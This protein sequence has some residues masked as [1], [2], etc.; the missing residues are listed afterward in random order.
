MEHLAQ[1]IIGSYDARV[2][3]VAAI[4]EATDEQLSEFDR[5]HQAMALE[6]R[7]GLS[8]QYAD[9]RASVAVQ[10]TEFRKAHAAMAG[11]ERADRA[12]VAAAL[13]KVEAARVSDFRAWLSPVRSA[14][15]Q[16]RAAWENLNATMRERR[17]RTA[18]HAAAAQTAGYETAGAAV[19]ASAKRQGKG[20]QMFAKLSGR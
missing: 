20:R 13:P 2:G 19:H 10:R 4:R 1:T 17:S 3:E 9:L 6:Q 14:H 11:R 18:T 7:A 12:K 5:S 15:A 8:E 16:A